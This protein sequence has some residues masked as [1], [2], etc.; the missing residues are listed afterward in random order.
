MMILLAS[1]IGLTAQEPPE[2]LLAAMT[3]G[4]A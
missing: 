1:G 2:R 4:A 3:E